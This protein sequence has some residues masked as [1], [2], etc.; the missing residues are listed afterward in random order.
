MGNVKTREEG[1]LSLLDYWYSDDMKPYWFNSTPEIDEKL[2]IKFEALYEQALSGELDSWLDNADSTLALVIL[3][4]QLPLNIYRGTEKS[5]AS[6]TKAI[7]IVKIT[8]ELGYDQQIE[9]DRL[10]FLYMPLMHSENLGDQE[11]SVA[12][13]RRLNNPYSLR[14]AEHHRDLIKRFGRFPHRNRILGR[15]SSVEELEYLASK[16]AFTG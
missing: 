8:L 5:F 3:L 15:E 6:E 9:R 14:F 16:E 10:A 12:L 4:D 11:Y 2:K 13:F 1:A 7:E